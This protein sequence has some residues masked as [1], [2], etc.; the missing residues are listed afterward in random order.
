MT[1]FIACLLACRVLA[2]HPTPIQGSKATKGP[3]A[4]VWSDMQQAVH[5]GFRQWMYDNLRPGAVCRPEYPQ[6]NLLYIYI[7]PYEPDGVVSEGTAWDLRRRDPSSLTEK[8]QETVSYQL[9]PWQVEL[10]ASSVKPV[11]H[12]SSLLHFATNWV[13]WQSPWQGQLTA[14]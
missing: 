7:G 12:E 9:G 1:S 4:T 14:S 2:N 5:G 11:C 13:V 3:L 10:A 8:E 6:F